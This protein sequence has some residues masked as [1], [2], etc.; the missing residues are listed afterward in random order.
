[1]QDATPDKAI[2]L[3]APAAVTD[4]TEARQ[5][6]RLAYDP[7][8]T[9]AQREW[10]ADGLLA[11][12]SM[13][14]WIGPEKQLKSM[15]ALLLAMCIAC[16]K[17]F[18]GFHVHKARRV[19]YFDAENPTE[20][21]DLR[22]KGLL[23]RFTPEEQALIEQNLVI[24]RGR[25]QTYQ[26][27]TDIEVSN[28]SF[29]EGLIRNYPAEVYILDALQTLHSANEI[30]NREMKNVVLKLRRYCGSES[31][32]IILH[33]TR[34]RD[35]AE[36]AR[37]RKNA[38]TLR[39]LGARRWSEK[40]LGAGA[41]KRLVEV[42]ICQEL[43][44]ERDPDTDELTEWTVDFQA[45]GRIIPDTPLL[46]FKPDGE[47]GFALV[48]ALYGTKPYSLEKLREAR[49]PWPSKNAAAKVLGLS[50]SQANIHIQELIQKQWLYVAPDG[51]V[52]L[53]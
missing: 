31:C 2:Q 23:S 21:I 35:D 7:H 10:V 20:E 9:Y 30:S 41:L 27:T 4:S 42:I 53:A 36:I 17:A 32:L 24:I 49:G 25:D 28:T 1:M 26:E 50:R 38:P 43:L 11:R 5:Y 47:Y 14:L 13:H 8:Q 29:W 6:A 15:L 40:C 45:F 16:G 51:S 34:K 44:E 48:R 37:N 12:R 33:H 39:R 46:Q 18:F 22:Y 52:H 19:V 3:A